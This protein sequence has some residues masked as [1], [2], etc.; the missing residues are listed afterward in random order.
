MAT[1]PSSPNGQWIGFFTDGSL[2]KVAVQG[3]APVTLAE[4]RSARG[5]SWGEDDVI[6]AGLVNTNGLWRIPAAG[7]PIQPQTTLRDGEVT[8]RWP[9]VLPGN[10]GVIFTAHSTLN[11]Y[12]DAS[13][14]V[15]PL[16][17]GERKT[18]WR[19]GYYG[20][21]VPTD[22]KKGHLI[23]IQRG[24][25]FGVRFD[26]DRLEL[27]GAPVPILQDVGGDPVSAAGRFDVSSTGMLAYVRGTGLRAWPMVWLDSAGTISPL[28]TKP[29]MYDSPRVSPDGRRI[30]VAIDSGSGM[31]I[32][33]HDFERDT[34][35]RLTFTARASDPVWTPDG[36]HLICR[37]NSGHTR[38]LLW[39]RADG[40]GGPQPLLGSAGEVED[41][42]SNAFSPDGR[43]FMYAAAGSGTGTDIWTL[44]LDVSDPDHPKGGQPTVFL[45]T[46]HN[47][48]RPALSPDGRWVA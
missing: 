47:E 28:F 21:F 19:G 46:A 9:Q 29:T 44:P 7:G 41:L 8:H 35:T 33:V 40:A 13:I 31:D 12:D 26:A 38:E 4:A 18:L 20:R 37:S 25:L 30:A 2:K 36:T 14:D 5:G 15:Q 39:I 43:L 42:S 17:T 11:A 27:E 34:M 16:P 22:G 6:I 24:T 3:G 23:F 32:S 10:R 48:R 45:Q 1:N